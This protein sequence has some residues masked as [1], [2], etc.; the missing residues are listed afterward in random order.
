MLKFQDLNQKFIS[1][2]YPCLQTFPCRIWDKKSYLS[3]RTSRENVQINMYCFHLLRHTVKT[4]KDYFTLIC[5]FPCAQIISHKYSI[6]HMEYSF[7]RHKLRI[8]YIVENYN[9][10][11]YDVVVPLEYSYENIERVSMKATASRGYFWGAGYL[12]LNF[13][14]EEWTTRNEKYFMNVNLW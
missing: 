6:K 2:G 4:Q 12:N 5:H 13:Y 8:S 9:L 3:V 1:Y 11:L 7:R 14:A 10:K